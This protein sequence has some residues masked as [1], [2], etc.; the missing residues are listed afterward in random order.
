[1]AALGPI[2][3]LFAVKEARASCAIDRHDDGHTMPW[4]PRP[5][6]FDAGP[7]GQMTHS[8]PWTVTPSGTTARVIADRD[9]TPL[10]LR[11]LASTLWLTADVIDNQTHQTPASSASPGDE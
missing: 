7:G 6:S 3:T 11:E 4:P 8:F 9:L 5:D 1:M 10:E 2:T